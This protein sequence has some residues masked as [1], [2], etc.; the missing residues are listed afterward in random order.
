MKRQNRTIPNSSDPETTK[1]EKSSSVWLMRK[2]QPSKNTRKK[3]EVDLEMCAT[4][5]KNELAVRTPIFARSTSKLPVVSSK[6]KVEYEKQRKNNLSCTY[7][8]CLVK[9][10]TMVDFFLTD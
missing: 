3:F 4:D 2:T 8:K 5:T 7:E 6:S 9:S 10:K 1:V